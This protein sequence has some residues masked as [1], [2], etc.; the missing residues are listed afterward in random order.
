MLDVYF[1]MGVMV[2]SVIVMC[3]VVILVVVGVDIGCGMMVIWIMLKVFDFLDYLFVICSDIEVVV[4]YGCMVYGGLGDCG[5]W[6]NF[7][8]LVVNI[9]GVLVE[10]FGVIMVKYFKIGCLNV[11]NYLGIFGM[12]N[13]FI[14]FCFDE[15]EWLWVMLYSGLCGIGNCVGSY[16]I[17]FVKKEM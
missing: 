1:G 14:E 12:G 8:V 11:V 7:F 10:C 13:Y 3:C 5:V 16:F 4:F 6:G 9:W 15:E 2:G 17:E